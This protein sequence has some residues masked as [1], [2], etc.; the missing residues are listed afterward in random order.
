MFPKNKRGGGVERVLNMQLS[1]LTCICYS[2]VKRKGIT[3]A[4][5][6]LFSIFFGRP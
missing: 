6:S 2:V 1:E 3:R 4:F 5:V